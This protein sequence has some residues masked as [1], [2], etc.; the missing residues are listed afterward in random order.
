[1]ELSVS[2]M[3]Q[4]QQQQQ[5]SSTGCCPLTMTDGHGNKTPAVSSLSSS[6]RS[7]L[8]EYLPLIYCLRGGEPLL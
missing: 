3:Q 5:G 4:Q 7:V 6:T 8:S 1:M 2:S